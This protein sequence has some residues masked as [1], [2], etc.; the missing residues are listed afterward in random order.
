[1]RPST[2]INAMRQR[3]GISLSPASG[4]LS[5]GE[6]V[7]AVGKASACTAPG[8]RILST[9]MSWRDSHSN[10]TSNVTDNDV[11]VK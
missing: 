11:S 6:I 2:V 5:A 8:H 3:I 4:N 9:S 1:M 10:V 7:V